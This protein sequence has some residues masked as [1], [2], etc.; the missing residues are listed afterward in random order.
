VGIPVLFFG[1]RSSISS[2]SHCRFQPLAKSPQAEAQNGRRLLKT[3]SPVE[4]LQTIKNLSVSDPSK[5]NALSISLQFK[6]SVLILA[7]QF[8]YSPAV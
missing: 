7:L 5:G 4:I 6:G 2:D 3:G 8:K 1:G